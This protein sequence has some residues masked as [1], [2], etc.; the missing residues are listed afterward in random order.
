[1]NSTDEHAQTMSVTLKGN[2]WK[3]DHATIR[4]GTQNAGTNINQSPRTVTVFGKSANGMVYVFPGWVDAGSS[5]PNLSVTANAQ[6]QCVGAVPESRGGPKAAAAAV[7]GETWPE[8]GQRCG[9]P[10]R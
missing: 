4:I 7:S 1:M 9:W 8:S 10:R 6:V 5:S 2:D 3:L